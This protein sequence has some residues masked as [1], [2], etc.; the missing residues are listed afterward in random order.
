MAP[1][2]LP[3]AVKGPP[4]RQ[5][6]TAQAP[7]DLDAEQ[8]RIGRRM[9]LPEPDRR[10]PEVRNWQPLRTGLLQ[11]NIR[12]ECERPRRADPRPPQTRGQLPLGEETPELEDEDPS[13]E[14]HDEGDGEEEEGV[15][16]SSGPASATDGCIMAPVEE[17]AEDKLKTLV[18][19]LQRHRFLR[20]EEDV[21]ALEARLSFVSHCTRTLETL[22][23]AY[24][25]EAQE[26][27]HLNLSRLQQSIRSHGIY[28]ELMSCADPPHRPTVQTLLEHQGSPESLLKK[29]CA[30]TAR[31]HAHLASRNTAPC[32]FEQMLEDVE[33]RCSWHFPERSLEHYLAQN[34]AREHGRTAEQTLHRL[35]QQ[36]RDPARELLRRLE[37]SGTNVCFRNFPSFDELSRRLWLDFLRSRLGQWDFTVEL[38]RMSQTEGPDRAPDVLLE[39]ILRRFREDGREAHHLRAENRRLQEE[40]RSVAH[41]LREENRRLQEEVRRLR[42]QQ[43]PPP[44]DLDS[45]RWHN[46]P[47]G[48]PPGPPPE[49]WAE[50]GRSALGLER[51]QEDVRPT[52][53]LPPPPWS[54]EDPAPMVRSAAPIVRAPPPPPAAHPSASPTNLQQ[55][56]VNLGLPQ[57]G[58]SFA[59]RTNAPEFV[60]GRATGMPVYDVDSH[61]EEEGVRTPSEDDVPP[62]E[63]LPS[64]NFAPPPGLG[65]P[66]S[67]SRVEGRHHP[68]LNS[69]H[70]PLGGDAVSAGVLRQPPFP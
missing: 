38:D 27:N 25:G 42:L 63:P 49:P 28:R 56:G 41:H 34:Q 31:V 18:E 17:A 20:G 26:L 54:S 24:I 44:S 70:A 48:P 45:T 32:T 23:R 68:P 57:E 10:R 9:C 50:D 21:D 47:P 69:F 59:W 36:S 7:Q 19:Q 8:F 30:L 15:T 14:G 64:M 1:K 33:N 4:P 6:R 3:V 62:S 58:P 60:P 11:A 43:G 65:R 39:Q 13:N 51:R 46:D 12:L 2:A 22:V 5:V 67:P 37:E 53:H 29:M 55:G 61:Q 66:P 16:S 35:V 52:A 40:G